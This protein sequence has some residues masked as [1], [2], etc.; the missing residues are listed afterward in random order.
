MEPVGVCPTAGLAPARA[1]AAS[2]AES[3]GYWWSRFKA[4]RVLD[5]P[6]STRGARG[7][8]IA[9]LVGT[10][11]FVP[12]AITGFGRT[13]DCRA[14]LEANPQYAPQPAPSTS[15]SLLV[16][17]RGCPSQGDAPLLCSSRASRDSS[18]LVRNAPSGGAP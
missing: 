5:A 10:A 17:A 11:V 8:V 7:T 18:A 2:L 6:S 1:L 14:W 4:R 13:Y 9:G 3:C 16:P 12:S 15:S